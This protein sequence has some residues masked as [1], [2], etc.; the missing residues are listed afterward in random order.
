[1]LLSAQFACSVMN[2]VWLGYWYFTRLEDSILI[3]PD[4]HVEGASNGRR[5]RAEILAAFIAEVCIHFHLCG[6]LAFD[7]ISAY[8]TY[9]LS[10]SEFYKFTHFNW[11]M[12]VKQPAL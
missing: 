7:F 10:I 9:Y 5:N 3:L 2:K 4:I 11:I 1:M 6:A 12:L 8:D